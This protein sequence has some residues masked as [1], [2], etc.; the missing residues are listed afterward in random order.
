MHVVCSSFEEFMS[1]STTTTRYQSTVNNTWCLTSLLRIHYNILR[2]H[3]HTYIIRIVILYV[4]RRGIG[5]F[6]SIVK[7]SV[8]S[9]R[10]TN[11]AAHPA[12]L[13]I[14]SNYYNIIYFPHRL[15]DDALVSRRRRLVCEPA[16]QTTD[17]IDRRSSS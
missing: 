9:Y 6:F 13:D 1:D 11:V 7:P 3:T 17:R 2:K 14:F 15:T 8:R 5:I 12:E 4:F 16:W 10:F